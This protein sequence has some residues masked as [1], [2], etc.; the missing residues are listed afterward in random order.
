MSQRIGCA[1]AAVFY[2]SAGVLHLVKPEFYLKIVPPYI[3]WHSDVVLVSGSFEIL[4]G[5]GLLVTR[6]RRA[7][8]WGLIALLL[9]V[10]PANV[11]LA[12]HPFEAGAAAINP[13]I[14]WGRLPIQGLLILWLYWCTKLRSELR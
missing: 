14:R 2:V 3:P 6:T 1:L 11:Y 9:A 10:F 8:A 5:L 7:A 4:G 13:M 12:T